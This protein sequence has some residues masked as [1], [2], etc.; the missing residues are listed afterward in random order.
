VRAVLE[1]VRPTH[2][3][4]CAWYVAHGAF[5]SAPENVDWIAATAALARDAA[6]LGLVRFVGV[7]SCAEYDWSDGGARP[8]REHDR[9]APA[10]L[11]GRAKA[12]THS[13]LADLLGPAGV[14][15]AW[16]RL[17]HLYGPGEPAGRLVPAVAL[18][19]IE[20]REARTGPGELRRDFMATAEAGAALAALL[21]SPVAGAVNVAS[22]VPATVAE[23]AWALGRLLGRP[24]LLRIG[25]L[26]ARSGDPPAMLADVRRLQL[27]VGFRSRHRLSEGLADCVSAL[28]ASRADER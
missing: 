24:E 6:D 25:A 11:Y 22:G 16:A 4:H 2:L 13:I 1:A 12:A 15:L 18:A 7:G 14:S 8:R 20:G 27:E 9:L 17:F 19:L 10:T 5:W 21:A 28:K 26:E 23:V 3:L